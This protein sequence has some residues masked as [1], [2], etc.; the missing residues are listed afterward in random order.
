M[1]N[2]IYSVQDPPGGYRGSVGRARRAREPCGRGAPEWPRRV[3][4]AQV[5]GV[6]V[7]RVPVLGG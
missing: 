6:H 5:R 3:R 2:Y 7:V 1:V 4:C